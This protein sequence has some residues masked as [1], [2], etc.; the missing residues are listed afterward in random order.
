MD[1]IVASTL[2][3][4]DGWYPPMVLS[5]DIACQ[6]AIFLLQQLKEFPPHLRIEL[7]SKD[8]CFAIPK[9][10][11][12]AHKIK[13]HNQYSLYLIPAGQSDAEEPERGWSRNNPIAGSTKEMGPGS[14]EDKLQDH[15][16]YNNHR[17]YTTMGKLK[18]LSK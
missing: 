12:N 15:M 4:Y 1:Y 11:F 2:G 3:H 5:Y 7:P 13:D 10:H 14:R 18:S 6:W 16:N 17:K 9:Y 8:L